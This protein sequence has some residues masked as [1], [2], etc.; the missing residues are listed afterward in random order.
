MVGVMSPSIDPHHIAAVGNTMQDQTDVRTC[1]LLEHIRKHIAGLQGR[2]VLWKPFRLLLP[3]MTLDLPE[4]VLTDA[5]II[6]Q[7]PG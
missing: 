4:P 1:L 6:L 7:V 2:K 5:V 3:K